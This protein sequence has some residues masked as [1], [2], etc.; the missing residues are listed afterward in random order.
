MKQI[1]ASIIITALLLIST[2]MANAQNE[3]YQKYSGKEGVTKVYISKAMFSLFK[4]VDGD[5]QINSS[6]DKINVGKLA[7]NLDGMYILT[8]ENEGIKKSMEAD[9]KEMLKN[10]K[11]E[12]LMEVEDDGDEVKM[13]VSRE[14]GFVNNFFMHSR[15]KDGEL[16]IIFLGGKIPEDELVK[17]MKSAM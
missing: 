11:L 2:M 8:S 7:G 13:Y 15:E 5:V 9:F 3:F 17:A 6:S 14:G 16:V 12:L 1:F 10:Y 4:N